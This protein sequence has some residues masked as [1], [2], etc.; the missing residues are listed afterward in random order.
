MAVDLARIKQ[1]L[2][3]HQLAEKHVDVPII[4]EL[5]L[6]KARAAVLIALTIVDNQLH[7]ILTQRSNELRSHAGQV[8]LPGGKSDSNECVLFVYLF[9]Y[10]VYH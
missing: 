1:C 4:D 10:L 3:E 6:F 2:L 7:V 8:A 9:I 5:V